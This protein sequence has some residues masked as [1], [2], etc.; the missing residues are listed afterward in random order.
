MV[1][2]NIYKVYYQ[3]LVAKSQIGQIDANIANQQAQLHSATEMFKNGFAEQLDV[4]K[5]NV[6]LANL[7]QKG[8]TFSSTSL[9][10][11]WASRCYLE[12]PSAIPCG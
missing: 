2:V 4:D 11:T 1:R 12:C 3:L 5:A 8:P 10:A 9:T 7:K 6:Q